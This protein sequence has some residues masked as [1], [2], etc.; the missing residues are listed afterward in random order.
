MLFQ[1][2]E[3]RLEQQRLLCGGPDVVPHMSFKVVV[4]FPTW[5]PDVKRK[6]CQVFFSFRFQCNK[7]A[8]TSL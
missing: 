8:R 6:N 2:S 4:F 3:T 7:Q 1:S 5:S